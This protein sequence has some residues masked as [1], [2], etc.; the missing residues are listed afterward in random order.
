MEDS[1]KEFIKPW[2]ERINNLGTCLP[3]LLDKVNELIPLLQQRL[4]SKI[5]YLPPNSVDQNGLD[6]DFESLK[7]INSYICADALQELMIAIPGNSYSSF[8]D[9]LSK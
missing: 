6:F 1:F 5:Q 9:Q 7:S 8:Q 2:N 4:V 3:L